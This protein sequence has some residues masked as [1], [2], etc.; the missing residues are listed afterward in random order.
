MSRHINRETTADSRRRELSKS[1]IPIRRKNRVQIW[2]FGL[3]ILLQSK[4]SPY[5]LHDVRR[6]ASDSDGD[7]VFR[8]FQIAELAGQNLL[9]GKVSLARLETAGNQRGTSFEVYK[10]HFRAGIKFQTVG[11]L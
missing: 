7:G 6:G 4:P 2:F 8:F 1:K 10:T 5:L 9:I 11:A 3:R